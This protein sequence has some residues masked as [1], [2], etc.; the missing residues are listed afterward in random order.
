M[1]ISLY[2]FDGK[3]VESLI[4]NA[5]TAMYRAKQ[6]GRNSC[7]LYTPQ[8][9]ESAFAK[10]SLGNSLCKAIER[11]ELDVY[12]Q[13]EVEVQSNQINGVEALM[14]WQHPELG[15]L[16]ADRF[17]TLAEE[18]GSIVATGYWLI[19]AACLQARAWQL[20]GLP[21][22]NLGVNISRHQFKQPDFIDR[23]NAI[24]SLTQ[25]DSHYLSLELTESIVMEDIEE[26]I[27]KLHQLRDMGGNIAVDNF[28]TG[29]SSLIY[30]KRFPINVLK[31]DRSFIQDINTNNLDRAIAISIITLAH[32]L[33]LKVVAEGVETREQ[34]ELLRSLK[35]NEMQGY[36]FNKPMPANEL[37]ELLA[38]RP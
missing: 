34:M 19:R 11:N 14:R 31:I 18:T 8:M 30:L 20:E 27:K 28:G 24:L 12:Y 7:Q 22:L 10:L 5:D 38:S 37:V 1:G 26:N 13:I 17:V 36:L 25:L 33:N 9:N 35:C 15:L 16:S 23:L 4:E 6:S 32:N 29:Y 2:P 3:D 21:A